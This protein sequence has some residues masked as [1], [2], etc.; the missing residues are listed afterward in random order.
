MA[1]AAST[2]DVRLETADTTSRTR[3][4]CSRPLRPV[5]RPRP[6]PIR[7]CQRRSPRMERLIVE[8][9]RQ[10]LPGP[11]R[12]GLRGACHGATDHALS[13]KLSSLV[14]VALPGQGG[15]RAR[16]RMDVC[17]GRKER[18]SRPPTG[19]IPPAA[20]ASTG[21][22]VGLFS[23]RRAASP[24]RLVRGR[25]PMP[26]QRLAGRLAGATG[27]LGSDASVGSPPSPCTAPVPPAPGSGWAYGCV[28][29]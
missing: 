26:A 5:A 18:R 16:P 27:I 3:R 28:R 29:F 15:A 20:L 2:A 12:G 22:R 1:G 4:Q 10:E 13:R 11:Q 7:L 8:R 6:A 9:Q 17:R 23:A 25:I 19:V 24:A 14:C 21:A